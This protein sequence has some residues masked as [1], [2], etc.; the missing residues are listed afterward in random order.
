MKFITVTLKDVIM[1]SQLRK[2][3]DLFSRWWQRF[4]QFMKLNDERN[5]IL[6]KRE[7]AVFAAIVR[8]EF[9]D[10]IKSWRIII[11]LLIILLTSLVSLYAS[12]SM[13]GDLLTNNGDNDTNVIEDSFL[14]LKL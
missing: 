11:L 3:Q 12:I 4:I 9:T 14:L 13:M 6:N 5:P 8:K 2:G 7:G 1:M 10:Y